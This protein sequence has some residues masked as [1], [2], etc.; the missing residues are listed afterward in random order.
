MTIRS[1]FLFKWMSFFCV[2]GFLVVGCNVLNHPVQASNVLEHVQITDNKVSEASGIAVSRLDERVL[3]INNDSGN[4]NTIYAV[5]TQGE[6]RG[7]VTLKGTVNRDWEDVAS[8]TYQGKAYLLVA[9]V[10]D[11]KA[12][13]PQYTIHIIPEPTLTA[14]RYSEFKITPKWSIQFTYPDGKHDCESVAV[15]I[16]RQTIL[17]LTKREAIPKLFELPLFSSEQVVATDLGK[18]HPIPEAT[19]TGF[20]LAGLLNFATMPTGMD[21][22]ADGKKLVV[23]TYEGAYLYL[24]P[25]QKRWQDIMAQPPLEI[26]LPDLTQAESIGFDPSGEHVY[27]TSEKIPAPL[28]KLDATV[29]H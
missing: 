9:D 14:E 27:V 29:R 24:N 1:T 20:S 3:W 7:A 28:Y 21:I 15:D 13:W 19:H 10:G 12:Q 6:L 17:L 4:P 22:S 5:S 23:V 16:Q 11:N 8:F 26:V 2:T 25:N 18:I